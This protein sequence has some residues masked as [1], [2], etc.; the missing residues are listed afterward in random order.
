MHNLMKIPEAVKKVKKGINMIK[1]LHRMG[2]LKNVD[3]DLTFG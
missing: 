3:K 1:A 2:A